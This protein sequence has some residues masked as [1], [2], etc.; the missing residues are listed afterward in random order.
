M[1][2]CRYESYIDGYLLGRL[3]PG[4]EAEFEEH[5]FNCSDC[6]R[7]TVEREEII[8]V[9]KSNPS[10]LKRPEAFSA[11]EPP[12]RTTWREKLYAMARPKQLA[13]AGAAA[14]VLV[15]VLVSVVPRTRTAPPEFVLSGEETVRGGT[16][17]LLSPAGIVSGVPAFFEWRKQGEN[18]EYNLSLYA[19]SI[20]W[21]TVTAE[22]KVSLPAEVKNLLTQ[23]GT[24]SWQ[25]KAFDR[26]GTLVALSPRVEFTVR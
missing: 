21:T 13:L 5:Y 22:T 1:T 19:P 3:S 8:R 14:A 25:V 20:L 24:Y 2:K 9:L 16:L 11:A 23:G 26:Q 17:T 15:F 6:F 7:K 10:L 4:E 12:R 18:L